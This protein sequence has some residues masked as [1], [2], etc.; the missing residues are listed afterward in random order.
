MNIKSENLM[1]MTKYRNQTNE[2]E[3]E[4]EK[5]FAGD[6]EWNSIKAFALVQ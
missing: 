5:W 6:S 3:K 4:I 1:K 2:T